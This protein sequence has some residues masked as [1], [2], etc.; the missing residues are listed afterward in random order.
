[1]N[2]LHRHRLAHFGYPVLAR[3]L[4]VHPI[5]RQDGTLSIARSF[6]ADDWRHILR[7]AGVSE[8]QAKVKRYFPFRLCVERLF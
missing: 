7:N 6:R 3:A 4:G 1:V 5:V 8:G 2:D